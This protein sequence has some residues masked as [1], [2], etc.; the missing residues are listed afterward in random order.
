MSGDPVP[1]PF[2]MSV[3]DPSAPSGAESAAAGIRRKTAA[4]MVLVGT[5]SLLVLGLGTGGSVVLARLLTPRD[6]GLVALGGVL[7]SYAQFLSDGGLGATLIRDKHEPDRLDYANALGFQLAASSVLALVVAAVGSQFGEVGLLA[8]LMVASLPILA[9]RAPGAIALERRLEYRPL[10]MIEVGETISYY[11]WAVGT[12]LLGWGVWG[13][14]SAILVRAAAGTAVMLIVGPIGPI[15]PRYSRARMRR[16]LRFGASYQSVDIIG[17]LRDSGVNIITPAVTSVATLGLWTLV[18]RVL[19]PPLVVFQSL[20]QV[21]FPGMARLREQGSNT[22]ALLER[23]LKLAT[24]GA[25]L[26]LAPLAACAPALIPAVFGSRWSAAAWAVPP[27]C[28][29]LLL[30]SPFSVAASGFLYAEG[31]PNAVLKTM[32]YSAVAWYVAMIPLLPFIGVAALGI[33]QLAAGAVEVVLFATALRR[34]LPGV[35]PVRSVAPELCAVTAA[36]AV[37]W[38]VAYL[39]PH[40]LLTMCAS[41]ALGLCL[42]AGGTWLVGRDGLKDLIAV[43]RRSLTEAMA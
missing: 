24:L 12:A 33:G 39:S 29:G 34:H 20:R 3:T 21:S 23:G 11:V 25:G 37:G 10:V 22:Q 36:A 40:T 5:R 18:G 2:D 17:L 13:L 35:R 15:L 16:L 28:L 43:T 31:D 8:A 41:A 9:F 19:Q 26:V 6:F 30:A 4:G 1:D 38:L 42:A 32:F 7:M 14:A 27:D